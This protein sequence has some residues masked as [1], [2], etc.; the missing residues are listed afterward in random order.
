MENQHSRNWKKLIV[1][2]FQF[3]K[4]RIE[5]I[6]QARKTLEQLDLEELEA[7]KIILSRKNIINYSIF[8]VATTVF[9][10]T[11]VGLLGNNG[12]KW[13]VGFN[14]EPIRVFAKSAS[15][16]YEQIV[17]AM[18]IVAW[19]VLLIILF[20]IILMIIFIRSIATNKVRLAMYSDVIADKK[21]IQKT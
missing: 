9:A 7:Q 21:E 20:S 8:G 16:T 1:Y 13:L 3:K 6:K 2:F 15:L 14:Q 10:A 17:V 5:A 18:Q 11:I 12:L 4:R 19:L